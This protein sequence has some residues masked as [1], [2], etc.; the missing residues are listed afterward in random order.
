MHTG[1]AKFLLLLACLLAIAA[2]A[3]KRDGEGAFYAM[4]VCSWDE[5]VEI[6]STSYYD[7]GERTHVSQEM[8]DELHDIYDNPIDINTA[9]ADELMRL[10]F[11]SEAQADS[12]VSYV[13]RYGRMLHAGELSLVPRL[14]YTTRH[15]LTAFVAFSPEP[16][17]NSARDMLTRGKHTIAANVATPLYTA[18]G[19]KSSNP[20][21][22]K[23]LG[24]KNHVS[25]KYAY[26]FRGE[27][28]FGLSTDKDAG[29]PFAC[30]G[31]SFMDSYSFYVFRAQRNGRYSFALGDYRIHL[32]EGLTAGR[33]Y[34]TGKKSAL[35]DSYGRSRSISPHT[36]QSERDFLR[37]AAGQMRMGKFSILAFASYRAGDASTDLLG[38]ATTL[39]S[40][41]YHRTPTEMNRK[42]DIH[43][44]TAGAAIAY[45]S[46]IRS[47]G[48]SAIVTHYDKRLAPQLRSYSRYAMTGSDFHA[49]SL[50]YRTRLGQVSG[51]GEAAISEE[52]ALAF[53]N[54]IRWDINSNIHAVSI[55]RSYSKK[56]LAPYS[57]SFRSYSRVNNEQ[58]VY[59]GM[60]ANATRALMLR[61]Y[62]DFHRCP[63]ASY[64][65][66]TPLNGQ[67]YYAEANLHD[68]KGQS[69][70]L[71]CKHSRK[72]SDE[73]AADSL[74]QSK[75]LLRLQGHAIFGKF[76]AGP[77]LSYTTARERGA[78]SNG[79]AAGARIRYT[80]RFLRAGVSA[81][82]FDTDSYS[83]RVYAYEENVKYVY[84]NFSAL[85]GR[86]VRCALVLMVKL[87]SIARGLSLYAKCGSTRY[88]DR[89]SIGTGLTHVDSRTKSDLSFCINLNI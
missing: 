54:T 76:T 40:D 64:R 67:E 3:Q 53:I 69:L 24:D 45:G 50:H 86:G 10:P 23:Y 37:G 16:Q 30:R 42:G 85:S 6:Y 15:L 52:G 5:F 60:N 68:Q 39:H 89:S 73:A 61:L 56:Y 2:H 46:S 55:Q 79:W 18:D 38:N 63:A 13:A 20:N 35:Y 59:L 87:E 88:F 74:L 29:E 80:Q 17:R 58:G 78:T 44:F 1:L 26:D 12:I 62:A 41:G 31:N 77:T 28:K 32:G 43:D 57:N 33:G 9:T 4:P 70:S 7:D 8:L 75:T 36:S 49:L 21:A 48:A 71:E 11:I 82:Y 22:S 25:A 66:R 72:T 81:T 19:Y 84:S 27:L 83:S 47:I 51:S 65:Y 34:L 14:D